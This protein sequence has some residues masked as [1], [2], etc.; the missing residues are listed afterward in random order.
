VRLFSLQKEF[1]AEQIDQLNG[2]FT[3]TDLGARFD[4][5]AETAAAM[6]N[7]DLVIV[8]DSS[9]AHLAG[10]LAVKAWVALPIAADWRWNSPGDSTP[11][12]QTLRLFRQK[13]WGD[14]N[15]V[16]RRM[17]SALSTGADI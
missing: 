13:T 1:G 4:D 17:A 12:Y 14:W 5:L 3:V 7:L 8:S 16:F 11:W 15:D 10:A 6:M 2:L 9:L